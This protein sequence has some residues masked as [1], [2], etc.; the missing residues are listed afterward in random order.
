VNNAVTF[1]RRSGI[2]DQLEEMHPNASERLSTDADEDSADMQVVLQNGGGDGTL[3]VGV[4][5]LSSNDEQAMEPQAPVL[6][7]EY[8]FRQ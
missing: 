5:P 8:V 3:T 1:V 6:S 7:G 4:Q 2:T